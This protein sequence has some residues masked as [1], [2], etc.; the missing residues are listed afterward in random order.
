MWQYFSSS[1]ISGSFGIHGDYVTVHRDTIVFLNLMTV[2]QAEGKVMII[3]SETTVSQLKA[4][5]LI[6]FL[7]KNPVT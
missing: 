5:C 3:I 1:E 7:T 4:V 2:S 6:F